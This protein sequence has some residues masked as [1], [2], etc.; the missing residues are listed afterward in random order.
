MD[1]LP[2]TPPLT[3]HPRG[4]PLTDDPGIHTTCMPQIYLHL[5]TSLSFI[6][7]GIESIVY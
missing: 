7:Q 5:G 2:I 1:I 3:L 6:M 4:N